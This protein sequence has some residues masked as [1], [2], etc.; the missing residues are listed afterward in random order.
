MTNIS[1]YNDFFAATATLF[2][3]LE[4]RI[5]DWIDMNFKKLRE[6]FVLKGDGMITTDERPIS[7]FLRLH[8]QLPCELVLIDSD[9][10]KIVITTDDN[11]HAHISTVNSGRTL[12]VSFKNAFRIPEFTYLKIQV[13]TRQIDTLNIA[14]GDVT[15]TEP[16]I[17]SLPLNIT[18]QSSGDT[19]LLLSAPSIKV[20]FQSEG[21]LKMAGECAVLTVK[22]QA[23]GDFD[24]KDLYAQNVMYKTQ[25]GGN[26]WIRASESLVIKHEADGFV[27]YYGEG[28]LKDVVHHGTGEIRHCKN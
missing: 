26:A 19:V 17:G 5:D 24:A 12:Y 7:S 6:L 25:S 13:Y 10:E 1:Y 21:S 20:K 27:H 16:Y 11:V 22:A 15:M 23:E 9:E 4:H 14:T 8:I 18:V 28:I 2:L 3:S